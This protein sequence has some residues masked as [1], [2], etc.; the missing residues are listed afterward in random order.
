[1][2]TKNQKKE[3]D[4]LIL[5]GYVDE[6]SQL[7]IP[8]YLSPEPRYIAGALEENNLTWDYIT[9]DQLRKRE[10]PDTKNLIV[11][12]GVTVPGNYL[13]GT[14]L[15]PQEAK[16]LAKTPATTWLAGPL[17]RYQ[18]IPGY[19]YKIKKDL[20]ASIHD[21]LNGKK[22]DRWKTMQ[23]RERWTKKA[24]KIT[25]KHP[26]PTKALMLE[27]E[28]Y[29]GCPRYYKNGCSF[30]TEPDYGKPV[31]REQKDVAKEIKAYNKKGIKHFRIGAQ[32]C[33]ISYK[34][35]AIGEKDPPKPRPKEIKEL[36]KEVWKKTPNIKVL[37]L[38]NANPSIIATYP[39]KSKKILKT[40]VQKT[41]PGNVLAF[42][43]ETADRRVI[44]KNNLNTTPQQ[45]HKAIKLVNKI[46]R[47]RGNNGLPKLLPGLNFL[48]GLHGETKQTYQKNLEFLRKI[49]KNNLLLRRTN[50]RKVLSLKQS[51]K[52]RHKN[53]YQ[54]F[55]QKV[56]KQ[57]DKPMLK[58]I[59]PKGTI[60][61]NIYVEEKRQNTSLGRQI[62]TYPLLVKIKYPLELN[63]F[64]DI[65]VTDHGSRSIT[66]IEYPFPINEAGYKEIK[67]LPKIGDK[68]AAKLFRNQPLDENKL[69]QLI[70]EK[71]IAKMILSITKTGR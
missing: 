60:L 44:E 24:T 52:L 69:N 17:A 28:L 36:F 14:P 2:Q 10:L 40:L 55:K 54:K 1:M 6:P 27:V 53:Q 31:F 64:H 65:A 23:E 29:R 11:Y 67:K 61:K 30:C 57:I 51:F 18:D 13:G 42:G 19:D 21:H 45:T 39:K 38:D 41:T 59:V 58:K 46:G 71:D 8:P 32:S 48:A 34:A 7:G 43:L 49:K 68:R 3:L 62:A 4:A 56:R 37:H 25:K 5:D 33:T 22:S 16:K 35:K 9:I 26:T 70:K 20:S 63:K 66:G 50:I 47:R 12:G 15:T